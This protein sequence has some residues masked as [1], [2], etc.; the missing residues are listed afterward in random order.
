[1]KSWFLG[2]H[3]TDL[4][5][6]PF[7]QHAKQIGFFCFVLKRKIKLKKKNTQLSGFLGMILK[8]SKLIM[9]TRS[10]GPVEANDDI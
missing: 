5:T 2:F 6:H 9:E 4:Q 8:F 10:L 7:K 1:M 3:Q